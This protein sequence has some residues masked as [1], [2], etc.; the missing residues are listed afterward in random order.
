MKICQIKEHYPNVS[1][2]CNQATFHVIFENDDQEL[3]FLR[4]LNEKKE[5]NIVSDFSVK[6]LDIETCTLSQ[7]SGG[8]NMIDFAKLLKYLMTLV[9]KS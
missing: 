8:M 7:I 3:L 2:L 5:K 6:Y 1:Y 4:S 9:E